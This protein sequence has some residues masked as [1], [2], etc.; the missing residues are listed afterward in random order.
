MSEQLNLRRA[1]WLLAVLLLVSAGIFFLHRFQIRRSAVQLREL[2]RWAESQGR[3]DR[4]IRFLDLYLSFVPED[5]AARASYG[6]L[7]EDMAPM[8]K[9]RQIA[10]DLYRQVLS[11]DPS[12]HD[13]RIRLARLLVEGKEFTEALAC[14]EILREEASEDAEVS[15]LAGLCYEGQLKFDQAAKEYRC[16]IEFAP[17]QIHF[18]E[19]LASLLRHHLDA[20]KAA[21]KVLDQMVAANSRNH[22]AYL[23]RVLQHLGE[24]N[25]GVESDLRQARALAPEDTEVLLV[26]TRLDRLN[27][28]IPEARKQLHKARELDPGDVRVYHELASLEAEDGNTKAAITSLRQGLAHSPVNSG[29]L[30]ALAD[31][32]TD[33]DDLAATR[34]VLADMQRWKVSSSQVALSQACLNLAE[35]RWVESKEILETNRPLLAAESPECLIE[36]DLLL[37][38]C[39]AGIGDPE[40]ELSAYRRAAADPRHKAAQ[41]A[42]GEA[43]ARLGHLDEAVGLYQNLLSDPKAEPKVWLTYAK[44]LVLRRLSSPPDN[45]GWGEVEQALQNVAR[46]CPGAADLDLLQAEILAARKRFAEAQRVLE[47]AAAR[48]PRRIEVC[49]ALASLANRQGK[50][51]AAQAILDAAEQKF[52]CRIELEL[53]RLRL[54]PSLEMARTSGLPSILHQHLT[55]SRLEDRIRLINALAESYFHWHDQAEARRL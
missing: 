21:D 50:R 11:E 36:T 55:D 33:T 53:T 17:H 12:R 15:Y 3:L 35:G 1:G 38:R 9:G 19:R 16:A 4:A 6:I 7:V 5:T 52:G 48:H 30:S 41:I 42:L 47:A 10:I 51:G 13:I 40:L 23:S 44:L 22:R 20:P 25:K 24:E 46:H 27:K 32:L 39:Y 2:S 26:S 49:L 54:A 28:K 14:L 18:Y 34:N 43:L 31:L 45:G 37:A 8:P 29:L